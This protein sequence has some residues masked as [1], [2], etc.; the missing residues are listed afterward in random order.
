MKVYHHIQNVTRG[1]I[2]HTYIR[3]KMKTFWRSTCINNIT[4]NALA[5]HTHRNMLTEITLTEIAAIKFRRPPKQT[6]MHNIVIIN[7]VYLNPIIIIRGFRHFVRSR[8]HLNIPMITV[9]S[10]NYD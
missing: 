6:H 2:G 3:C 10:I 1:A 9:V 5:Q 8:V 4:Q 7:V